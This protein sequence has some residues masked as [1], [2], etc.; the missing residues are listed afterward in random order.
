MSKTELITL[1]VTVI[2]RF[3][4]NFFYKYENTIVNKTEVELLKV[5]TQIILTDVKLCTIKKDLN[6][7]STLCKS[8]NNDENKERWKYLSNGKEY[9]LIVIVTAKNENL[10]YPIELTRGYIDSGSGPI[11]KSK[12]YV[13]PSEIN[14][15]TKEA[16]FIE[17]RTEDEKHKNYWLKDTDKKIKVKFLNVVIQ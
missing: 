1:P 13:A 2:T 11:Y 16:V 5:S 7:L 14:L 9:K 6:K 10:I 4:L 17:L 15:T 3:L 8:Q 12:T